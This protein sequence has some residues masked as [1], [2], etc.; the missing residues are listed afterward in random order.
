MMSVLAS[1]EQ[2]AE[3]LV[4]VYDGGNETLLELPRLVGLNQHRPEM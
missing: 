3:S 4:R 2:A 1:V